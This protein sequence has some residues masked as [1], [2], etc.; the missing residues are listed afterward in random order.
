MRKQEL[1]VLFEENLSLII[2]I[3]F[4][5]RSRIDMLNMDLVNSY[6]KKKGIIVIEE[7]R[8]FLL[9][10]LGIVFEEKEGVFFKCIYGGLFV[11]L[12]KNFICIFNNMIKIINKMN[13]IYGE[14][15]IIQGNFFFMVDKVE[16]KILE[17]LL[18]KYLLYVVIEVVK[19]VVLY[20]EYFDLNRIIEIDIDKNN[21]VILSFGEF[22]D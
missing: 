3:C 1:I 6:F 15:Y 7:N 18:E 17:I 9:V 2:E 16:K 13:N 21:I 4:I 12:D 19:N 20:R 10:S 14:V 8:E 22:I 5:I 11:F